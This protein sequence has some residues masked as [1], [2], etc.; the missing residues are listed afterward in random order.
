MS[1]DRSFI[2]VNVTVGESHLLLV[3]NLNKWSY[4]SN[5]HI[6]LLRVYRSS[7]FS[8]YFTPNCYSKSLRAGRSRDRIPVEAR[9]SAS[10]Q[11]GRGAHPASYAMGTW[12]LSGGK[13]AG[14]WRWPPTPSSAEVKERVRLYLYTPSRPSWPVAGELYLYFTFALPIVVIILL[15]LIFILNFPILVLLLEKFCT[16]CLR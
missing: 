3:Q 5:R 2:G 12:S 11:T 8:M 4:N 1:T 15:F 7:S 6:S 14:V 9:I 16:L 10:V 13:A